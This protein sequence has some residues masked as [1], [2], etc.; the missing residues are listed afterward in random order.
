MKP[1]VPLPVATIHRTFEAAENGA[2]RGVTYYVSDGITVEKWGAKEFTKWRD[3]ADHARHETHRT[4]VRLSAAHSADSFIGDLNA[5]GIEVRAAH[6]HSLGI[7]KGLHAAVEAQDVDA[8]GVV[9][10]PG[11]Q[12]I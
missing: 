5:H 2:P 6:W 4:V 8:R 7:E 3:G 12:V 10:G 11:P 1:T 9:G